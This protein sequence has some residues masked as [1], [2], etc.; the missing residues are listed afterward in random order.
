MLVRIRICAKEHS[1]ITAIALIH[2]MRF[3]TFIRSRPPSGRAAPPPLFL[4]IRAAHIRGLIQRCKHI[5]FIETSLYIFGESAL[6]TI[7]SITIT[8]GN[9]YHEVLFPLRAGAVRLQQRSK[10][11][12]MVIR[13]FPFVFRERNHMQFNWM[14]F[15]VTRSTQL[16]VCLNPR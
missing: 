9:G 5:Q 8:N 14:W 12:T 2:R 10:S 3:L 15:F 11:V 13:F 16:S 6:G 4:R 7:A 1:I